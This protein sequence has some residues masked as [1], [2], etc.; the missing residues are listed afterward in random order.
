ME[1]KIGNFLYLSDKNKISKVKREI[2]EVSFFL[3]PVKRYTMK[4]KS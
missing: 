1:K 2:F 4:F 3:L